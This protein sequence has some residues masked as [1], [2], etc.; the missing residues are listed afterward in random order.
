M[1]KKK[2]IRV[3]YNV[4]GIAVFL[5]LTLI[6]QMSKRAAV[7]HLKDQEPFVLV[8]NVFQLQYL[9]NR[10]ASFR[11][12]SGTKRSIYCDYRDHPCSGYLYLRKNAGNQEI[13]GH[14]YSHRFDRCRRGGK[15][16]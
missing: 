14:A 1:E 2:H 8:R 10:G 4:V 3:L 7:V 12:P 5:I 13:Y 16:Y 9:E 6:D 11:H 15:F